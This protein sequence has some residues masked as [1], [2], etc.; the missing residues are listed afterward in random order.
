MGLE[1]KLIY[2][3]SLDGLV[4]GSVS[5]G[6][7][8]LS[9]VVVF[10]TGVNS[11]QAITAADLG[12]IMIEHTGIGGTGHSHALADLG[13]WPDY[14][15]MLPG[16]VE[17][18]SVASGAIMMTFVFPMYYGEDKRNIRQIGANAQMSVSIDAVSGPVSVI[19]D[20]Y[21][22]VRHGECEYLLKVDDCD[23]NMT[24]NNNFPLDNNVGM[25]MLSPAVTTDPT[26]VMIMRGD[27]RPIRGAF[28]RLRRYYRQT[29]D[30]ENDINHMIVPL[31]DEDEP[32]VNFG[33]AGA[34]ELIGG[35]GLAT[36]TVFKLEA[37]ETAKATSQAAEIARLGQ[38]VK[39]LE[40]MGSP[41]INKTIL[42][43]FT[44]GLTMV[45]SE[46]NISKAKTIA[47]TVSAA[48]TSARKRKLRRRL[49]L[50]G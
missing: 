34:L 47:E 36:V 26:T 24:G 39:E 16:S 8:S 22:V 9:E 17:H 6:N 11:A 7:L 2:G 27:K 1:R 43:S 40:E 35:A 49:K 37:N 32:L 5:K 14:M 45:A 3:N 31:A 18:T 29:C 38:H 41:Q 44:S 42:P 19:Y 20:V 4:G 46:S 30:I 25:V 28:D 15:E 33:P 48:K 21:F 50:W 12:P 10:V 23:I 13:A